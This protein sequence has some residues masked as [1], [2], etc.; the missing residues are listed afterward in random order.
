MTYIFKSVFLVQFKILNPKKALLKANQNIKYT[1]RV[2]CY[3]SKSCAETE[4]VTFVKLA[5]QVSGN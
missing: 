4:C 1:L 2:A 5:P 3:D